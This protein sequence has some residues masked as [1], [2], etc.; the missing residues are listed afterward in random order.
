MAKRCEQWS[1]PAFSQRLRWSTVAGEMALE[2][3]R[4]SL[5]N[6]IWFDG[7]WAPEGHEKDGQNW[8]NNCNFP[9]NKEA[10]RDI[11]PN[12]GRR[13]MAAEEAD[14]EID[15]GVLKLTE[16]RSFWLVKL[17]QRR[18][19]ETG[20][21]RQSGWKSHFWKIHRWIE[22]KQNWKLVSKIVTFQSSC[23]NWNS[24]QSS[25]FFL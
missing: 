9:A 23:R 1:L 4:D 17:R 24:V 25:W 13:F 7:F 19:E 11:W 3:A 12:F 20:R 22:L 18:G 14:R 8:W 16:R 21:R 5:R 15:W 10:D 6:D 2:S